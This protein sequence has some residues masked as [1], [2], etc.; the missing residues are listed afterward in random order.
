MRNTTR[1]RRCIAIALAAMSAAVEL[2]AAVI[3]ITAA[4]HW[5][6]KHGTAEL[7]AAVALTLIMSLNVH[8]TAWLLDRLLTPFEDDDDDDD[9]WTEVREPLPPLKDLKR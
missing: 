5:C 1:W 9:G 4:W 3:G 6:A 2:M 8:A 7:V